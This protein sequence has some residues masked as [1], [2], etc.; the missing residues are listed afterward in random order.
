MSP[1]VVKYIL[2]GFFAFLLGFVL[3]NIVKEGITVGKRSDLKETFS[4][5]EEQRKKKMRADMFWVIGIGAILLLLS[6]CST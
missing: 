5:T 1:E 6:Q 2:I 3:Y 4:T